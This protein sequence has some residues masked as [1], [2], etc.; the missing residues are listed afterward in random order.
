MELLVGRKKGNC[1]T[2]E[3]YIAVDNVCA[4]P[5]LTK[6]PDG[7]I[8]AAARTERD[9][10]RTPEES[11]EQH[12][13]R[14]SPDGPIP[15]LH[16]A[17]DRA[18]L[19]RKEH[20]GH[21]IDIVLH[22][23]TYR[24]ARSVQLTGEDS[25]AHDAPL[26]IRTAPGERV[27][28]C[29]ARGLGS[30]REISS[31]EVK[32]RLTTEQRTHLVEISMA[33]AG[34][35][36][37]TEIAPR[38]QPPVELFHRGT[39]LS[40]SRYPKDG[41]LEIE[42]VPQHGPELLNEG[43]ERE[44][45][46]NDVP[47]G[48]HYGRF[49]YPGTQPENW[50]FPNEILVHGYWTWDW[51][52]SFQTVESIDTSERSIT[53]A[54]PHHSYGYTKKQRFAFCNVLEEI[55]GPGQW[56]FHRGSHRIYLWPVDDDPADYSVSVLADPLISI[57]GAAHVRVEGFEF[58]ESL[59]SGIRVEASRKV[60]VAG[61][62]FTRLG[63]TAVVIDGRENVV[64]SSDFHDLALGAISVAG[65]DRASLQP[66]D[67][68]VD[69]NH[70][71]DFSRWVRTYQ[72]A[73]SVDGVANRVSHNLV[74]DAPQEAM[75]FS[76]NEHL[77]EY[78]EIHSVTTETGDSGAIHTG[79]NWTWR[80]TILRFNL[81]HGL[82]GTGLHGAMG[83]YLDDF[84]SAT[85]IQGNIFYRAGRAAFIGGGRDNLVENNL[86]IANKASVHLD[87]RG[88]S[89]ASNYF[90]GTY[91]TLFEGMDAVRFREPPYADRYPELLRLYDDDP[92]VPKNNL[93][94]RNIS[95]GGLWI[96]LRDP[97]RIDDMVHEQNYVADEI[98]CEQL[99]PDLEVDPYFL[100]IDGSDPYD[101]FAA[102]DED[103]VARF[104]RGGN[105]V[106]CGQDPVPGWRDRDFTVDSEV[107]ERIGFV[108]IPFQ[109]I[110]L[111]RDEY[112]VELPTPKALGTMSGPHAD[113]KHP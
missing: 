28:L 102:T 6:M 54:V 29:G 76:G 7:A 48:R 47:V 99:R 31:P 74:H 81:I 61:C 59:G 5:N 64:R 110:G 36:P 30:F 52:D 23:G 49:V 113:L 20:P 39:R 43:L 106:A 79:R 19:F 40:L 66:G 13:I 24:F 14:V 92:A 83:I 41:W 100:N 78:N 104:E 35:P 86:F 37:I 45:R 82:A 55:G 34:I 103:Q 51:N 46:Y 15:T 97:V 98:L 38:G 2:T 105:I 60:T 44:K 75:R 65:G 91:P 107:A 62:C 96:E 87:A 21:A 26:A 63:D 50:S 9:I 80:G 53:V 16:E 18:R 93:I 101:R 32:E 58:C 42:D 85:T 89:W 56:C 77:F 68:L 17:V 108:Q 111:Y 109:K 95:F 10:I 3:R 84:M 27:V 71:W 70:I 112:R 73:V 72:Y 1:V 94:R 88:T 8:I 22:A 90:D 69:N 33:D 25:G 67:N 57:T 12:I 4:W 11:M